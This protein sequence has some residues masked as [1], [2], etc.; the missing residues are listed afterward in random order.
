MANFLGKKHPD[1]AKGV[2]NILKYFGGPGK[3]KEGCPDKSGKWDDSCGCTYGSAGR[4]PNF[5][6]ANNKC[7][8]PQSQKVGCVDGHFKNIKDWDGNCLS[9]GTDWN[10]NKR[11][12]DSTINNK[13]LTTNSE[14]MRVIQDHPT[15]SVSQARK[16]GE[17][18]GFRPMVQNVP[19][20]NQH[21]YLGG[22]MRSMRSPLD[23]TF[24]AHHSK[25]DK[26][27]ALWQDC[28]GFEKLQGNQ[29]KRIHYKENDEDAKI[30][31]DMPYWIRNPQ[32]VSELCSEKGLQT[33]DNK[34]TECMG[35]HFGHRLGTEWCQ[36]KWH[37]L[38]PDF[39]VRHDRCTK[40]CSES[41]EKRTLTPVEFKRK[42][43]QPYEYV[44][45]HDKQGITVR[46]HL[47]HPSKYPEGGYSYM[48]DDFDHMISGKVCEMIHEDKAQGP[49]QRGQD[50]FRGSRAET[51]M[52]VQVKGIAACA[53]K[54]T[55][56]GMSE[57]KAYRRC[58]RDDSKDQCAK[59]NKLAACD[60][61]DGGES[62]T[63][64]CT[65]DI[66]T[67]TNEDCVFH[68]LFGDGNG[69]YRGS[70]RPELA[71]RETSSFCKDNYLTHEEFAKQKEGKGSKVESE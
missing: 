32:K 20:N 22:H 64:Q 70:N 49:G 11:R 59:K 57:L 29:L 39:C 26:T 8:E 48:V 58:V 38:C 35:K 36:K 28:H 66:Q 14:L 44:W 13:P 60:T 9:R 55:A 24:Y 2:K 41:N 25:I 71:K 56:Q 46:D 10:L 34:C 68:L 53:A 19:H 7:K 54:Y 37:T 62:C 40:E 12:R 50:R 65:G 3:R 5:N 1:G 23:P 69:A 17:L 30:D 52:S 21:N 27:W 67:E 61:S 47:V 51:E 42:D 15:Y 4:A 43:G 16:E 31:K 18:P 33:K 63:I 45:N 6:P